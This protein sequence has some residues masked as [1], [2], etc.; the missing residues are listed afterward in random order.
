ML[1]SLPD[2][3][4]GSPPMTFPPIFAGNESTL[5]NTVVRALYIRKHT[6]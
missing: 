5:I 6:F 4:Q 2:V 3:P 1:V